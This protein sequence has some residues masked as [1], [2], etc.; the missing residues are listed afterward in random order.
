MLWY[1]FWMKY[2]KISWANRPR[3]KICTERIG[4]SAIIENEA[5]RLERLPACQKRLDRIIRRMLRTN[6]GML[7]KRRRLRNMGKSRK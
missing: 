6:T 7:I 1:C 4:Y 5:P 2:W 3:A